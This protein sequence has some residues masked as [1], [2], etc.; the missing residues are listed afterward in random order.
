M[1]VNSDDTR[2]LNIGR[3]IQVAYQQAGL[4]DLNMNV[5]A[6]MEV[7]GQDK[8][9]IITDA[10][11]TEGGFVR[12]VAFYDLTTTKDKSTYTLPSNMLDLLDTASYLPS[13]GTGSETVLKKISRD[14]WIRIG[15]KTSD[16][17]PNLYY[18]HRKAV[19][20]EVRLWPVPD[21]AATIKFQYHKLS[22]D[23]DDSTKVPDAGRHWNDYFVFRMAHDMSLAAGHEIQ[24]VGYFRSL[25]DRALQKAKDYSNE[26][27]IDQ[28][29][30][31]HTSGYA[32]GMR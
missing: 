11:V 27:V 21:E 32:G 14:E 29:V 2:E 5:T 17:R 25:A 22:A 8:L 31:G 18:A 28:I 20:L 1:A 7:F 6:E 10:L 24:R 30:H 12:N 4:L 23:S 13:G 9:E 26:L 16:G 15:N 3:L 19:P